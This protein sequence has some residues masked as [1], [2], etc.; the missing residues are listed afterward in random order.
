MQFCQTRLCCF[1]LNDISYSYLRFVQ[2]PVGFSL[3]VFVFGNFQKEPSERNA[4][5]CRNKKYCVFDKNVYV[6]N[7]ELLQKNGVFKVKTLFRVAFTSVVRKHTVTY[8][9]CRIKFNL[10]IR[11]GTLKPCITLIGKLIKHHVRFV[12]TV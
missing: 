5:G 8:T 12:L 4:A 7:I 6:K 3:T 9:R 11:F 10:N 1:C 2:L